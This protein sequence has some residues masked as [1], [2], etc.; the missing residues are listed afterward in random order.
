VNN[1]RNAPIMVSLSLKDL[2]GNPIMGM[3]NGADGQFEVRNVPPGSYIATAQSRGR[4]QEAIAIQPVDVVGNHVDGI[5]LTME[6]GKD[7]QGGVKVVDATTPPEFKN[8]SVML[9]PVGFM[10]MGG[11]GRTRVG[12]D[13]KFTLKSVPAVRYAVSVTG[14]PDTCYVKSIQYGG[15]DV[16][17]EGIEMTSGATLDVVVSAAA[18][19]VDAVVVDKDGKAA[20]NATVALAAK[21]STNIQVRT[22]DENGILSLRGLKP[23]EYR[24]YAWEDVEPGAPSDPDF[25]KQYE[26][27]AKSIK[28]DAAGHEAVQLKAIAIDEK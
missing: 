19:Q 1:E 4:G 21:D 28:L 24:M 23:G 16:T 5:V 11:P 6:A 20:W 27:Q 12:E 13:L 10:G 8:L 17:E 25:L 14:L 7:V 26:G 3:A 18:A 15:R 2:P 22:A 9:R